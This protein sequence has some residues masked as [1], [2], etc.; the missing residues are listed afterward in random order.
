ME[1]KATNAAVIVM[2]TI[3]RT[4]MISV[5]IGRSP[6]YDLIRPAAFDVG[7]VIDIQFRLPNWASE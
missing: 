2:R 4:I 7:M 1:V 3:H 6:M 5:D